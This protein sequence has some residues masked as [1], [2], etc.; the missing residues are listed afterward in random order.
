MTDHF[1]LK[2]KMEVSMFGLLGLLI[3]L[4]GLFLLL[5]SPAIG[6]SLIVFGLLVYLVASGHRR[7]QLEAWRH[8]QLVEAARTSHRD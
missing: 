4:V 8:R 2:D 1:I 3:G 6:L 7:R 5:P